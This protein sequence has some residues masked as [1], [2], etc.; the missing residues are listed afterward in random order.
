MVKKRPTETQNAKLV[1]SAGQFLV[2]DT[3]STPD[4]TAMLGPVAAGG[5]V[6]VDLNSSTTPVGPSAAP[7]VAAALACLDAHWDLGIGRLEPARD[8]RSLG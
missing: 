2:D 6:K 4:A 1:W 5:F 3:A 8:V 7:R